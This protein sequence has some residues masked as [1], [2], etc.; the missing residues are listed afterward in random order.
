M[1]LLRVLPAYSYRRSGSCFASV[2]LPFLLLFSPLA[3]A[4]PGYSVDN[5]V[6]DS[7]GKDTNEARTKALAQGET[8]AF[9]QLIT[10]RAPAKAAD[11]IQK[12]PAADISN[13]IS[14]F[15][16]MEEKITPNHYHATLRYNFSSQNI[17]ALLQET[18]AENKSQ[19]SASGE[20]HV[21]KAVL[22]LPVYKEGGTLKLWQDDNKWRNIW[23]E[24]AL[25]SG[26]G[27][28]II[29]QGDITDRVD[30]DDSNVDNATPATLAH[31]YGRYGVGEIYIAYAYFNRKADPKPTLEV[32][33]KK[34]LVSGTETSRSDF[35]IRS[36]DTL[37]TLMARASSEIAGNIYKAQTI[38][39]NKIEFDRV[40]EINARVNV[41]DIHEWEDLRKRLLA[42]GNIVNIRLTSISFYET[43]MIISFKGTPDMLGK[44]LVASGLRVLQD[45]DNLVLKLK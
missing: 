15:E 28:V 9:K 37:D 32:T 25:E 44:T 29:P 36:S 18:P 21:S 38:N 11:I 5:I 23:Y 14:G 6:V 22:I 34:L 43:S 19:A 1:F 30:V 31:M 3:K 41:T 24:S 17:K 27:L 13:T 20:S 8:E 7:D 33:I 42:H 2:L 40:K 39:P 16:V 4:E 45:G 35:I 26:G 10:N 12:I